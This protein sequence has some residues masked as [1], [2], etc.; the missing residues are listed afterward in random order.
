ME[1]KME[2]KEQKKRRMNEGLYSF[3]KNIKRDTCTVILLK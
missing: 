2:G 3:E 1:E